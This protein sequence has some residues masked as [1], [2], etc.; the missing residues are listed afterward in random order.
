MGSSNDVLGTLKLV[1]PFLGI[2]AGLASGAA[3][4]VGLTL[5]VA[6]MVAAG[7]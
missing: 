7:S 6:P 2:A 5:V 1:Q 4:L 3:A